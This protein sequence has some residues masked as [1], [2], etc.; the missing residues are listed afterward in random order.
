MTPTADDVA[1]KIVDDILADY[2][3][4]GSTNPG[5]QMEII[6]PIVESYAAQKVDDYKDRNV[7]DSM[8]IYFSGVDAGLEKAAKVL[9]YPLRAIWSI[10]EASLRIRSMKRKEGGR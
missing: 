5:V 2:I 10:Q 7:K 4:N 8:R 1:R 3:K 6:A 9:D